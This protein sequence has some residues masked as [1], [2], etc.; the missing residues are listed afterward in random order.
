MR[1]KTIRVGSDKIVLKARPVTRQQNLA[2]YNVDVNGKRYFNSVL[3]YKE[4]F[5]NSFVKYVKE[6]R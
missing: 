4:A 6:N 3:T 5:D 2:G 1:Q